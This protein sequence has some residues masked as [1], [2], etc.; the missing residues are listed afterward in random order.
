[1]KDK[2]IIWIHI[3]LVYFGLAKS[4][5]DKYDCEL[6][7]VVDTTDRPKKFLQQQQLV[8]FE[9]IWYYHD[10]ISKI[11][12]KPN[13][14]YLKSIEKKHKINLWLLAYN[15]RIFYEFN[16]YY[17]FT[18]DEVLS[19]LEQECRLFEGILDEINPDFL[20]IEQPTLHHNHLFYE[21]CKARGVKIL[22]LKSTRIGFKSIISNEYENIGYIPNHPYRGG[23]RTFEDLQKYLHE[24]NVYDQSLKFVPRFASSKLN[25]IKAAL[26]FLLVSNN[27]N[28]RTHYTYYG[29]TK[30]KV[31]IKMI[32]YSLKEKY[33]KFF[34]DRNF[35][36]EVDE[37][38]PFIFFPLPIDQEHSLLILSPFYTNSLEVIKHI[39]KSLPVGYK[40]FVKENPFMNLRGWRKISYY[41]QI[42]DLPNV[43]L[44]HPSI[45]P[46]EIMKK[47]SLVISI[48]GTAS[49]E[50]AFYK[51]PS[52]VFVDTAFSM[53]LSVHRLKAL[54]ELPEAIRSSLQKEVRAVD[55]NNYVN[56][57]DES[58]FTFDYASLAQDQQDYFHYGGYLVDVDIPIHK[59]KSFLEIHNSSFEK[60][61][62]EHIKKIREYKELESGKH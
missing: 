4:L 22:L 53:L 38:T 6:F 60:L 18:S 3:S 46:E 54:E 43:V 9:K 32:I 2:I 57:I 30:S 34:I 19:I 47:C 39:I 41:K 61:A 52:I 45:R 12:K 33:R 27:S 37:K 50:A 1:M 11:K 31:L 58:F 40:L 5:K 20:I 16:D 13:L 49:L 17:K 35:I 24:F 21:I 25:L 44:L 26:Q 7:A 59:M 36:R 23:N 55:L 15:E 8:H 28:S 48:S 56:F 42:M 51:K 10:H 14:A 62:L 29:R